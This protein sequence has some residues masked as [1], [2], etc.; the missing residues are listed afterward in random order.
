MRHLLI[1][2][3]L[4]FMAAGIDIQPLQIE[5][6]RKQTMTVTVTGEVNNEGTYTLPMYASIQDALDA[7]GVSSN[8]DL[9]GINPLLPLNDNDTVF[10]PARAV[11]NN[12]PILKISINAADAETLCTLPGIGMQTAEKIIQYRT[13]NGLFQ[14]LEELMEVSG[15]GTAKYEKLRDLIRL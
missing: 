12:V 1:F 6:Y 14:T 9:S 8:A 15:I 11:E 2:F 3:V 7:A 10:V 4:V 5:S 13:Q